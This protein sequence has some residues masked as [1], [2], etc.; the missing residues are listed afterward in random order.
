M[1]CCRRIQIS[2]TVPVRNEVLQRVNE[3]RNILHAIKRRE[4]N[5]LG[6]ILPKNCLLKHVIECKIEG[7]SDGNTKEKR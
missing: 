4:T 6:H 2:W 7:K 1:W 3:E 5:W